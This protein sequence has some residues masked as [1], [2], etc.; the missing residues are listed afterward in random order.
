[1][2]RIWGRIPF[3][4]SSHPPPP[5]RP[6]EPYWQRLFQQQILFQQQQR[7]IL[8]HNMK[9]QQILKQDAN[10]PKPSEPVAANSKA[11][12]KVQS[13]APLTQVHSSLGPVTMST[14]T[15]IQDQ[16][17]I[18]T[19]AEPISIWGTGHSE[20]S[21]KWDMCPIL[22]SKF[23]C[24]KKF[25]AGPSTTEDQWPDITGGG[26]LWDTPPVRPPQ[27]A[28]SVN[29]M[30]TPSNMLAHEK[31]QQELRIKVCTCTHSPSVL[32]V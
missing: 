1:M 23:S 31:Q 7:Q 17:P 30:V 2:I 12:S 19:S 9:Q 25:P 26:S 16:V 10:T 8:L 6:D 5:I 29:T 20:D 15:S 22:Q 27:P 24:S 21:G 32:C 11:P 28:A 14:T 18:A 3:Q 4:Q 13:S